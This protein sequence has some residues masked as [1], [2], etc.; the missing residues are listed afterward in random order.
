MTSLFSVKAH[1]YHRLIAHGGTDNIPDTITDVA[2]PHLNYLFQHPSIR[3]RVR[4]HNLLLHGTY[5]LNYI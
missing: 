1:P 3:R 2:S 4:L 5:L